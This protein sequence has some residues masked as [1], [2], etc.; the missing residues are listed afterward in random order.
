MFL[1]IL[2][3]YLKEDRRKA[4]HFTVGDIA[5]FP[6][7]T[8]QLCIP[9]SEHRDSNYSISLS[10]LGIVTLT[11]RNS[12]QLKKKWSLYLHNSFWL[13][14]HIFGQFF[15]TEVL[16]SIKALYKFGKFLLRKF[17]FNIFLLNI[18]PML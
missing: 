7:V 6:K 17:L 14:V 18:S 15:R 8:E 4:M 11:M 1:F 13:N 2:T 16:I 5:S 3:T 9:T 10:A 12:F